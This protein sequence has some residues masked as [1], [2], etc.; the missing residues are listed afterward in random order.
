MPFT[1]KEKKL[2]QALIKEKGLKEGSRIY[3]AMETEAAQG[4]AHVNNFGAES[5][6][7]RKKRLKID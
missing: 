6:A 4:K 1:E 7:R 2:L 3:Q 5:K